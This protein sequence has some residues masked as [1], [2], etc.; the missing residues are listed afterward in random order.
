MHRMRVSRFLVRLAGKTGVEDAM[1]RWVL[2]LDVLRWL[3]FGGGLAEC[4]GCVPC[5]RYGH[6]IVVLRGGR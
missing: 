3:C 1:E 6:V 5:M 4:D 2:W